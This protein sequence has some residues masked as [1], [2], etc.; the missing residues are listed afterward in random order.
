MSSKSFESFLNSISNQSLRVI[1]TTIINTQYVALDLSKKNEALQHVDVS[2]SAGLETYINSHIKLHN[3]KA[4]FGGYIE[5]RGIYQRSTY[6]NNQNPETERNIHLGV[7][8]WVKADAPIYT[9]LKAKVH[10]FKNF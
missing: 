1:D 2:S 6:F 9:P 3:A 10:S 4:A 5:T 7:D 8:L